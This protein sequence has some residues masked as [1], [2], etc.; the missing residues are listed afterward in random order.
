VK[1][2][3]SYTAAETPPGISNPLLGNNPNPAAGV[4]VKVEGGKIFAPVTTVA[5]G[6]D[7][8]TFYLDNATGAQQ[9]QVM[10]RDGRHLLGRELTLD[11]Q[12]QLIS[13]ENGFAPDTT[14]SE[15]YLNKSGEYG[16]RG[17]NVLYGAKATVQYQQMFD[18]NG[19]PAQSVPV[20]AVLETGRVTNVQTGTM[21]GNGDISINGFSLGPLTLKGDEKDMA[22]TVADWIGK[23]NLPNVKVEAFNDITV[24]PSK[25]KI[26]QPLQI[27]SVTIG[28][29]TN[30]KSLV[31][32]IQDKSDLTGVTARIGAM[33]ELL[34]ENLP[35]AG[36]LAIKIGT[37]DP[38][39]Y[40]E[41]ALGIDSQTLNGKIRISRA[42]DP[43][44]PQTSDI[45][46]SFGPNGTPTALAKIGI[47][48][49]AYIEGKVP[50]DLL[51]FVT[52]EGGSATVATSY[53]GQ[54]MLPQENLR[55]Q[56]LELRF[57]APDRY[58]IVDKKTGTELAER[59]YDPTVLEPIINYHGLT[60]KLNFA[61]N[62]G[63][64][65]AIDGNL[66]GIGNNENMLLMTDLAKKPIIEGKTL[67][68]TYIDQV[69]DIGN[70]AQQA[71]ITQQALTV[72][73]EQAIQSRDSA[74]GVNLDDEAAELIRFQQAYQASAKAMQVS[75]QLFDSILQVR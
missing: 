50:D 49:G 63:D 8:P 21:I 70:L 15:D 16:Y 23:A 7:T 13:P 44:S 30:F 27:N 59:A 58:V 62:V 64:S 56:S 1:A 51:V 55:Q 14:Y 75:S 6:I 2:S 45:S 19:V 73:N 61:P 18:K 60:I 72:V 17:M 22:Q 39:K 69:N 9:L 37:P 24:D 47:R 12:F 46:I 42:L 5:A 68:N 28:P 34:L 48:T 25:L 71:K 4:P 20:P 52:G 74:S 32:A 35:S 65:F 33:G 29:F 26:D 38:I 31:K 3:L 57:T 67:S 54:P 11:E 41:N 43:I 36:G 40:P 10:T 66:D 53:A